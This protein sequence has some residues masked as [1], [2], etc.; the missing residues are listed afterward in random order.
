MS[1]TDAAVDITVT[2]RE[3]NTVAVR[4]VSGRDDTVAKTLTGTS[5]SSAAPKLLLTSVY[6]L[7]PQAHL[8]AWEAASARYETDRRR[9]R[10]HPCQR[11]WACGRVQRV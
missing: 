3:D 2:V 1:L 10:P 4:T 8:A 6:A 7:C 9:A 11:A 5:L